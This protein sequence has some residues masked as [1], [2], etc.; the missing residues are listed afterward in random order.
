LLDQAD[1]LDECREKLLNETRREKQQ[2]EQGEED[3][4]GRLNREGP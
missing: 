3:T 2:A 1:K 4:W